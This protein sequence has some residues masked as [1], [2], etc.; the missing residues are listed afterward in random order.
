MLIMVAFASTSCGEKN[1][2]EG[3]AG[4][5]KGERIYRRDN[6][7]TPYILTL[8]LYADGTGIM[9]EVKKGENGRLNDGDNFLGS[10]TV[11]WE[12][13]SNDK[14]L[15]IKDTYHI[16]THNDDY[17]IS[18]LE[19]DDESNVLVYYLGDDCVYKLEKQ[20]DPFK[21]SIKW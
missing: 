20:L 6:T 12:Y 16:Y 4:Y 17:R 18:I 8:E 7:K 15:Y 1:S 19:Y 2:E 3:F 13:D 9:K 21:Y 14:K 11:T 5:W 10:P